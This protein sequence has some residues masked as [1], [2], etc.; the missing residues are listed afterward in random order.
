MMNSRMTA[1]IIALLVALTSGAVADSFEL[2][3]TL[4]D[5]SDE[6]PDFENTY[7]GRYPLITG[8]VAT[9]LDDD[10]KPVLNAG[11]G[12]CTAVYITSQ[13]DLSNVV[14]ELDDGTEYKYDELNQGT[15]GTFDVPDGHDGRTIVGC[16]VKAGNNAS[17]DGPG[18]G[19]RFDKPD[20]S[21]LEV[22]GEGD[23][24]RVTFICTPAI[25]PQWR[26]ESVESF[27][28]WF[29]NVSGVNQS[30]PH[31]ITLDNG[32]D[33]P[34]G[35]YR[36]EASKHNGQSFFPADGRM[37]GDEGRPHNYHFTFEID[38]LFT[39]TDPV[40]REDALILEFSGDDDV[41]V[42]INNVLVV[43]LGGVHSEKWSR[44]NIDDL[45]DELGLQPGKNYAF[46][47]F[48]SERHTVESNFTLET[49]M[50]FLS[51]LYD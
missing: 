17:G 34:G 39:Y 37:F 14:V 8:M 32:Q 15:T 49:N 33:A 7:N 18:Y 26:I 12:G 41:W 30:V 10:G 2:M 24:I 36:F 38:T 31:T 20:E 3:G 22:S 29:R 40:E 19:E 46:N 45:A 42:F 4:R 44:V 16:W 47:F 9:Q 1:M 51:P 23:K 13:K 11:D 25:D 21:P 43:D 35:I 48:F 28:Q 6:H 50:P 27:N 5:F